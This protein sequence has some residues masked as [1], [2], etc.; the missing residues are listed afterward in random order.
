MMWLWGTETHEEFVSV[1]HFVISAFR[2]VHL[3]CKITKCVIGCYSLR[4]LGHIVDDQKV[5]MTDDKRDEV[6]NLPFPE[7]PKQ[8]RAALGQTNFQRAFI[9]R[10]ATITKPLTAL[11]NG[12]TAQMRTQM[13]TPEAREA[14]SQLMEAV[15]DQISLFHLDYNEQIRVRV[16]AST[17]RDKS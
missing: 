9:P 7:N 11:V 3:V 12:T 14:W 15:A 16:D 1:I 13:R 10:Y 6:A 17:V 2:S 5:R 4:L 8:L